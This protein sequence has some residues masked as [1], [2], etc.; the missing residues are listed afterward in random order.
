MI[1]KTPKSRYAD[2]VKEWEELTASLAAIASELP[3]LDPQRTALE[4]F[5]EE[6]RSL[7]LQ[8]ANFQA[9]KQKLSVQLRTVMSEGMKVATALRVNLKQIY[10]NRS[11]DLV[12]FGI[13]PF[14]SRPRKVTP[15][16]PPTGS[17]APT[18]TP[19]PTPAHAAGS[20][21]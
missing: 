12:K 11:E 17:P 10:G 18:P 5:L 4:R 6:A 15:N 13:Q 3:H 1:A 19:V 21:E 16:P 9:G 14:R 20:A 7:T 2:H 8:Q